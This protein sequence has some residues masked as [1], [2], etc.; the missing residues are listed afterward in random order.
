MGDLA[1]GGLLLPKIV[2]PASITTEAWP[3]GTP[4]LS[5]PQTSG[6]ECQLH[7]FCSE[8]NPN[9]VCEQ[10]PAPGQACVFYDGARVLGGGWIQRAAAMAT[11]AAE[12]NPSKAPVSAL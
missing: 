4:A 1:G 8:P 2:F 3:P 10:L 11:D 9:G 12:E 6:D 7:L 5:I